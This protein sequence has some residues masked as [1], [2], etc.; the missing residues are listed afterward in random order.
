MPLSLNSYALTSVANVKANLDITSTAWDAT[1]FI[2][3]INSCTDWIEKYCGGRRFVDPGSDVTEYYESPFDVGAPADRITRFISVKSWPIIS[4]TS[5]SFRTS[6]SNP[7]T[8]VIQP[9]ENY[10]V[11]LPEG[12]IY[13]RVGVPRGPQAVKIIYRG[14]YAAIPSDLEYAC[15]KMVSKEF[16][17]RKAEGKTL[18][19]TGGNIVQ[20]SEGLDEEL[21]D[22]LSAYRRI[23]L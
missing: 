21:K 17:R 22:V 2:T 1:V 10:D 20:W 15:I 4:V 6:P 18:E 13:L 9:V 7:W 16:F 3:L 8:G 12:Q 5:L 14:G 19:R 23:A 11:Y